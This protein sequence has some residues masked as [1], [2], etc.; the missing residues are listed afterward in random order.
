MKHN[1]NVSL[2][3][4][5]DLH[6]YF[7]NL[8]LAGVYQPHLGICFKECARLQSCPWNLQI[9]YLWKLPDS[10]QISDLLWLRL[11]YPQVIQTLFYIIC[12]LSFL[13]LQSVLYVLL[14]TAWGL[15]CIKFIFL[16]QAIL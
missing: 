3:L 2:N 10:T 11:D 9:V 15:A 12:M 1:K 14:L 13:C 5:K 4:I 16:V 8:R 6:D 7:S